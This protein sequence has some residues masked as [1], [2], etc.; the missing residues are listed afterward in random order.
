MTISIISACGNR[1]KALS[2]SIA[3]WI[4]FDEVDEIIVTDWNSD[5]SIDHL[6]ELDS[7][8]KIITVPKTLHKERGSPRKKYESMITAI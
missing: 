5:E 6:A 7:R 3:S 1:G 8:I 4:E 2:I